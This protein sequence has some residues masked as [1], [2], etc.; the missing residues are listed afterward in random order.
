VVGKIIASEISHKGNRTKVFAI[1]TPAFG[2]GSM[3]GTF[4]GG[5]LARPYGRFPKWLGGH[6]ELV[7]RWPFALPGMATTAM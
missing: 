5:E 3:I 6:T 2:A 1:F 7:K 4:L